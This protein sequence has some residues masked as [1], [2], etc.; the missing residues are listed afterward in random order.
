MAKIPNAGDYR[1]RTGQ[2]EQGRR[3]APTHRPQPANTAASNLGGFLGALTGTGL[4]Y[5]IGGPWVALIGGVA[6]A[7]FI[8]ASDN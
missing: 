5:L 7:A 2:H 6:L 1:T 8:F 3:P 4:L